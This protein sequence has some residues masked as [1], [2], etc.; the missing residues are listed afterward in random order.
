MHEDAACKA[1]RYR[2][3]ANKYGEL[4]KQAE[5]GY[6]ADVYRKVAIRYAFMAEDA[7]RESERHR[8]AGLDRTGWPIRPS[9]LAKPKHSPAKM[10]AACS[11]MCCV[12]R[13]PY[14]FWR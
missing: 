9:P 7:L 11:A 1:E 12:R 2:K 3:E 6:L 5:P 14:P 13:A 4:A 10:L 8:R